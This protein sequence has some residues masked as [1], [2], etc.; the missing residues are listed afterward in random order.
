MVKVMIK[1]IAA[2]ITQLTENKDYYITEISGLTVFRRNQPSGQVK[3]VYEPSICLIAQG[4]KYVH[5]G[6][7]TYIYDT[8]N[9]LFSGLHLP[10]VSEVPEASPNKPYLG[11]GL[12]LD[13]REISQLM[14]EGQL[15]PL[16]KKNAE[17]A[18]ETGKLDAS[19]IDA[20]LRLLN[21]LSEKENIPILAPLIKREIYYRLLI[22]EHGNKLRKLATIGTQ[23]QRV[24]QTIT[25]LKF[26]FKQSLQMNELAKK[27]HMSISTYHHYFKQMTG[28]S[29]LQ[30]QKQLRL[31]EARRLM[32]TQD[33]DAASAA[34]EV[35]YQSPSQFSREYSRLF[36]TSPMSNIVNI[37]KQITSDT[38]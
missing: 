37:R 28:L 14:I 25:W 27:A 21:L 7:K 34:F 30:Y 10:A 17:T 35:G 9:Y 20:F 33:T 6:N 13:Y 24:G 29:P 1:D 19:L 26:N 4:M 38:M 18:M 11:L 5:L 3:A 23:N 12:S 36:G 2:L 8:R 16:R 31:Q 15:Q 32:L 22:G